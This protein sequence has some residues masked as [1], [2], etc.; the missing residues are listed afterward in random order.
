MS[1]NPVIRDERTVAVEN[2][3]YRFAYMVLSFGLL[4]SVAVRGLVLK[5]AGWDLLG[6]VILGGAVA[7]FYQARQ[8]TLSGRWAIEGILIAGV[9]AAVGVAV[10]TA[11]MKLGR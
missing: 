9:A 3:S 4:V 1:E 2:T 5:E 11:M 6:L 10:L 8:R 7:G